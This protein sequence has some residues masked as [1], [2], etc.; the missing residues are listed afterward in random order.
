V[1]LLDAEAGALSSHFEKKVRG[2]PL[3]DAR[4]EE[5]ISLLIKAGTTWN[6]FFENT[7]EPKNNTYTA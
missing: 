7:I 3:L 5:T 4:R 6:V 1:H 2:L